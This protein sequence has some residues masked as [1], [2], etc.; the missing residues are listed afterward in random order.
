MREFFKLCL[1]VVFLLSVCSHSDCWR[2][3]GEATG[4]C[5]SQMDQ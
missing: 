5:E 3:E 2:S 4:N 1:D